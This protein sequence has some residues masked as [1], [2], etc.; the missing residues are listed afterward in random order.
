MA[1]LPLHT[2]LVPSDCSDGAAHAL[3]EAAALA[4]ATGARLRVLHVVA[5]YEDAGAEY[6]LDFLTPDTFAEMERSAR[7]RL[8][9][10]LAAQD[11]QDVPV[12]AGVRTGRTVDAI[13][14]DAR[15][16]QVDL[17]VMSTHGRTGFRHA[18][19]GSVTERVVR[20]APCPVLS[21]RHP[22]A[23]DPDVDAR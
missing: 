9:R 11:L 21:I 16:A 19:I 20:L 5:L 13:L 3:H 6:E 4:K 8:D 10:W 1:L 22:D 2:V 17:I 23:R 7:A 15:E 12:E 14:T 18:L